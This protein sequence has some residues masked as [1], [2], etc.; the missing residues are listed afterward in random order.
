MAKKHHCWH[1]HKVIE[2][3]DNLYN[4]QCP[5]CNSF[6]SDKPKTEA[7]Y[8]SLQQCYLLDKNNKTFGE[9]LLIIKEIAYN[10]IVSKLKLSGKFLL[11]EQIENQV[12]WVL[13]KMVTL[14][15]NPDFRISVSIIEFLSQ[16]VLYP[17]YNYKL[18]D[19]EQNEI[20]L[21]TPI[22]NNKSS[23]NKKEN[24][25]FDIMKE[26]PILEDCGET[27]N[28]FFNQIQKEN[29]IVLVNDFIDNMIVVVSN[30]KG[31]AYAIKI[32][33][34]LDFYF[35]QKNNKLFTSW[36]ETEGLEFKGRFRKNIIIT[37]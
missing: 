4:Y 15:S 13:V 34:L 36:W 2:N 23:N 18:Q 21:F 12:S 1:C 20:S 11:D 7:R 33:T 35:Q 37:T 32:L 5:F 29:V 25:L 8:H 28:L 10:Q 19:K 31:V 9:M 24:T 26:T 22:T 3:I 16:V 14:Y 17:L 27:E 30:K 6:F